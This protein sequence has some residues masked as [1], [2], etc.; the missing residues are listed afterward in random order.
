MVG[1]EVFRIPTEVDVGDDRLRFER[2]MVMAGMRLFKYLSFIS[3][4]YDA[5]LHLSLVND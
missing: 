3:I 4:S 5:Q 1:E 2:H